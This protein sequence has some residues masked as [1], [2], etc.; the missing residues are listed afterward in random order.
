MGSG[1]NFLVKD[2]H[3][4][5]QKNRKKSKIVKNMGVIRKIV[6]SLLLVATFAH[7]QLSVDLT[8]PLQHQG[9]I[10]Q[11]YST[12]YIDRSYGDAPG[13]PLDENIETIYVSPEEYANYANQAYNDYGDYNP[14]QAAPSSSG[15][16]SLL[17]FN[18]I[19]TSILVLTGLTL[20]SQTFE[21]IWPLIGKKP[22][23][24]ETRMFKGI[25]DTAIAN[26]MSSIEEFK[27]KYFN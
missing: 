23:E 10:E 25:E 8:A 15:L 1:S 24:E 7:G 16:G 6:L 13:Q 3:T 2:T 14:K 17:S 4:Y 12:G 26:I 5:C 21:K 22:T 27:T 9:K 11:Q 20:F 19:I 18:G